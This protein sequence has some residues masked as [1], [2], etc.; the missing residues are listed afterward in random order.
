MSKGLMLLLMLFAFAPYV[1]A[2]S[3]CE[4]EEVDAVRQAGT[5]QCLCIEAIEDAATSAFHHA[6]SKA[7]KLVCDGL[8][9]LIM[10]VT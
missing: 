2:I 9:L 6:F 3:N 4:E 5:L 10:G 8:C 1:I 7:A